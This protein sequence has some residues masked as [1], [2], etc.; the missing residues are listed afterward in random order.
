MTPPVP[1][2]AVEP[3]TVKHAPLLA[4]DLVVHKRKVADLRNWL[5]SVADAAGHHSSS[6]LVITG[7]LHPLCGTN[8][9]NHNSSNQF[10]KVYLNVH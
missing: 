3:W 2:Q 9:H 5:C 4:T 6:C 10:F 7:Q 8:V 1:E